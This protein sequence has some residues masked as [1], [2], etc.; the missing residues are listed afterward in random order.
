M[1]AGERTILQ[2]TKPSSSSK[3][4]SARSRVVKR[5][6]KLIHNSETPSGAFA[7]HDPPGGYGATVVVPTDDDGLTGRSGADPAP[8]IES[9][10]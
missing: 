5:R 10:A 2:S 8:R 3:S 7:G 4:C 1:M 6:A 9:N